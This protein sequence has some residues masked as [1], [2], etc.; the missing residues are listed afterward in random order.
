[1]TAQAETAVALQYNETLPAPLVVAAGRGAVAQAI[2]RVARESGVTLVSDSALAESLMELDVNTLI[3]E[4]LYPV[5]AELLVFVRD[6]RA[7]A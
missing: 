2:I 1:M 4:S 7:R 5:I 3:P 6:L